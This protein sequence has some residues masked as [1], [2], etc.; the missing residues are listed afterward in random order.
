MRTRTL[1]GRLRKARGRIDPADDTGPSPPDRFFPGPSSQHTICRSGADSGPQ[2]PPPPGIETWRGS[3]GLEAGRRAGAGPARRPQG[4][5]GAEQAGPVRHAESAGRRDR[6]AAC[7]GSGASGRGPDP[8]PRPGDRLGLVLF[9]HPAGLRGRAGSA[10]PRGSRSTRRSPRR[11]RAS[12]AR[13]GLEVTVGRLHPART[14]AARSPGEPDPGQSALRPAPPPRPRR[15]AAAQGAGGPAARRRGQRPGRAVRLFPPALPTPGSSEGG[16]AAW[17]IPSEFM[18]V[19]YGRGDPGLPD[20]AGPAPPDPPLPPGRRPVRR[21]PGHLGGGRLREGPARPRRHRPDVVR[22]AAGPGP[23]GRAGADGRHSGR[24]G[25]GRTTREDAPGRASR[26]RR[27]P[28]AT[29]SRSAGGWSPA[30]MSSSSSRATRPCGRGLP[31]GS[32]GR[33]CPARATSRSRSSR[34]T[35]TGI[36]RSTG[37]W[38]CSTATAPRPRSAATTPP[39]GPTSRRGS[40]GGCTR[41]T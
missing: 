21:R 36:P 38:C 20:R 7:S 3:L 4:R 1:Q 23:T 33:S 25:S 2:F 26:R 8:V 40:P 13:S 19:N 41:A 27:P 6:R 15:E 39:S 34:P 24:P 31:P 5:R 16:L 35:P 10:R 22:R 9:G 14:A 30:R 11:P 32:S 28:S 12:G 37:P 18:D 17:L 29:S